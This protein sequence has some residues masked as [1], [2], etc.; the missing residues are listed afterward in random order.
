MYCLLQT[1]RANKTK[2]RSH[3][4]NQ[5]KK[6]TVYETYTISAYKRLRPSQYC[7]RKESDLASLWNY[8]LSM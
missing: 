5:E 3:Y 7:I 1:N 2:E 4:K 6:I 8:A